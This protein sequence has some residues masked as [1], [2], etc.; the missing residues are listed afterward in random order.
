MPSS[1]ARRGSNA[2]EYIP[3]GME[4]FESLKQRNLYQ[5][6]TL[7]PPVNFNSPEFVASPEMWDTRGANSRSFIENDPDVMDTAQHVQTEQYIRQP[8][9]PPSFYRGPS[10]H[11]SEFNHTPE[12]FK[13]TMEDAIKRDDTD[14]QN[15]TA[16][17]G[18]GPVT[19]A[20]DSQPLFDA[21][22]IETD[23]P[24][25]LHASQIYEEIRQMR[26]HFPG[27]HALTDENMNL[28][29]LKIPSVDIYTHPSTIAAKLSLPHQ[30]RNSER[31]NRGHVKFDLR[32]KAS[33]D[34]RAFD[35]N[36]YSASN[37]N[38]S[39]SANNWEPM[40]SVSSIS[41]AA[42]GATD[43]P[44]IEITKEKVIEFT[45]EMFEA[46]HKLLDDL[47]IS[48]TEIPKKREN[49]AR[50][51]ALEVSGT[52]SKQRNQGSSAEAHEGV[53]GYGKPQHIPFVLNHPAGRIPKASIT[54]YRAPSMYVPLRRNKPVE[55]FTEDTV[56]SQAMRHERPIVAPQSEITKYFQ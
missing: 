32:S 37:V 11:M 27:S 6:I 18:P 13:F 36:R 28:G 53:Y 46:N 34:P 39:Q 16:V 33:G 19:T 4:F 22:L 14:F 52:Y 5:T 7:P 31:P 49:Y 44:E 47:R 45:P 2:A 1:Q 38:A 40:G 10:E 20:P 48:T 23:Q 17:Y 9:P 41:S 35:D 54:E 25:Q 55:K 43:S 56:F 8:Q 50:A 21:R 24:A 26:Q 51:N 42:T 15:L 12:M 3:T 29:E 30:K